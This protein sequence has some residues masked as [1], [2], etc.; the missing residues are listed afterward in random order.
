MLV[1][2]QP[3]PLPN[4]APAPFEPIT[5]LIAAKLFLGGIDTV[6]LLSCRYWHN[7][8]DRW[9][10]LSIFS[11][12]VYV[13][14][15]L[16]QEDEEPTRPV[17]SGRL[18]TRGRPQTTRGRPQTTRGRPQRTQRGR[19][20]VRGRRAALVPLRYWYGS[21]LPQ[22]VPTH[23]QRLKYIYLLLKLFEWKYILGKA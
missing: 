3:L 14:A 20:P 15:V 11:A 22:R 12:G 8:I 1:P 17:R 2:V 6:Q 4:P 10:P 9:T 23:T 7:T 5:T 18:V 19:Q 21:F 16:L 13:G